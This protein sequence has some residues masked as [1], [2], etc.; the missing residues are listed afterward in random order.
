MGMSRNT[1]ADAEIAQYS[2]HFP[3]QHFSVSSVSSVS[4]VV[5]LV[6]VFYF[7]NFEIR[8]VTSLRLS[9]DG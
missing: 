1:G 2:F 7:P 8:R 3:L 9:T 6:L 4:S 5:Q